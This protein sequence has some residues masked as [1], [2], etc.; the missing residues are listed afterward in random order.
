MSWFRPLY[1]LDDLLQLRIGPLP[2]KDRTASFLRSSCIL[3]PLSF[4]PPS[5]FARRLCGCVSLSDE[6]DGIIQLCTSTCAVLLLRLP[7]HLLKVPRLLH[8]ALPSYDHLR[9]NRARSSSMLSGFSRYSSAPLVQRVHRAF[10]V[11]IP[12]YD[13]RRKDTGR[14]CAASS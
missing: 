10:Q 14:F 3:Y 7:Q 2:G 6:N 4:S 12:R 5:A 9:K 11:P 8:T 13:H 1:L